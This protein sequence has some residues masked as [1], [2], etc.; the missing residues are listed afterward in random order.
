MCPSFR[1]TGDEEHVTRGRANTLRLAMAGRLGANA[2]GAEELYQAMELCVGC[3][4][5]RRECPMG[6]DVARMKVEALHQYHLLHPRRLRDRLVASLPTW[7]RHAARMPGLATLGSRTGP[8]IGFSERR[9]LPAWHRRPFRDI[10]IE[11]SANRGPRADGVDGSDL[12]PAIL[13]V[14]TFTRWFEPENARAALRVLE[15]AG[16]EAT[17]APTPASTARPLC[18]GRTYLNAGMVD[19]ARSEALRLLQALGD[20]DTPVVGLEPSCLLT[21]RDE[22]TVLFPA[23]S[24]D[25]ERA[26][27][28]SAR[29]VLLTE[30]LDRDEVE[31]AVAPWDVSVLVHGHCHQKA[32]G[33]EGGVLRAL[34]SIP[35]ATVEAVASGCCGMAGTFGYEREHY[36]LSMA[37]G[38]LELLPAVRAAP[39]STRLVADGTSCRAQIEHGTGRSAVHSVRILAEALER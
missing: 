14:D 13:F 28:L 30:L 3:K 32:F 10:E 29:A 6:I 24:R 1:V 20:E 11:G 17:T 19:E 37:M 5:C 9:R 39:T 38:E 36:D 34:R 25:A 21:L 22:L 16:Y 26:R 2:L 18:C 8:L 7:A 27:A 15:A 12:K 35:G 33:L 31:L 4:A 23:G